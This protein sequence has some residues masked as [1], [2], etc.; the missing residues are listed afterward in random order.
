MAHAKPLQ[1]KMPHIIFIDPD[2]HEFDVHVGAGMTAMEAAITREVPGIDADCGGSCTC[3]TCHVHVDR[4]WIDR[5]GKA[6]GMEED[7]LD[8]A[9]NSNDYSRLSCQIRLTPELDG[10]RLFIPRWQR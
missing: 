7:I 3:S 10:L 8:F 2:G 4:D 5:V 1:S 9:V 6:R